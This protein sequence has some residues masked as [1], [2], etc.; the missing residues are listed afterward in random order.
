MTIINFS[1]EAAKRNITL[2]IP[3]EE[4]PDQSPTPKEFKGEFIHNEDKVR[5]TVEPDT[6]KVFIELY[7]QLTDTKYKEYTFDSYTL[8]LI[9][10]STYRM[11]K[12]LDTIL[13]D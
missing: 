1:K 2:K 11:F 8:F 5:I 9:T 13:N 12:K 4:I 6:D 10:E 3:I 7:D